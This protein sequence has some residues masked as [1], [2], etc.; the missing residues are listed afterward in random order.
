M[1]K[2]NLIKTKNISTTCDTSPDFISEDDALDYL[3]EIYVNIYFD[4]A[5]KQK[6]N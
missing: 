5:K 4:Y 2:K 6:N 3:A 1:I